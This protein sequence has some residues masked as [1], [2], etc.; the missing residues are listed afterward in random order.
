MRAT[1]DWQDAPDAA[2]VAKFRATN[3]GAPQV[4]IVS[5]SDTEGAAVASKLG[6]GDCRI[7]RTGAREINVCKVSTQVSARD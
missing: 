7:T 1:P 5:A 6:Y 2:S 4:L 3:R